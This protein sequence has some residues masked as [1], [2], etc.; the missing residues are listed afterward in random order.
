MTVDTLARICAAMRGEVQVNEPLAGH[1]SLKVGGPADYFATPADLADLEDLLKVVQRL[2][3]PYFVLGGGYNVLIG[4]G[5]F[6]GVVISLKRLNGLAFSGTRGVRAEAG[7][8]N[9]QLVKYATDKGLAG[10]EFLSC[11]PGTVGGAL[12]VNA[13]AHSQS[14]VGAVESLITLQN[15]RLTETPA[16]SLDFGYRYLNLGPGEIVVAASFTLVKGTPAEIRAKLDEFRRHRQESQKISYPNAGSFFKN[17]EGQQAWR[18]ID[19]AGFRGIR[20]GGAQVAEAHTNFLVNRGGA[21]AAD[22]VTLAG[23]IKKKVFER[24]GI[25]LQEEVRMLGDFEAH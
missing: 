12:S 19:E 24:T 14:V 18:L 8:L 9:Q 20:V 23:M 6:R 3:L 22:F 2:S 21:T 11:I 16:A 7:V 4:D 25:M 10:L 5:G 17:P 13:G 15:G 1:T